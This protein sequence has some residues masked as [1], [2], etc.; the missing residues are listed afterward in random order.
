M[1]QNEP[2]LLGLFAH[3]DDEQLIGA[4]FTQAVRQGARAWVV[5]ATRGEAGQN[6]LFSP[7]TP[8]ALGAARTGE[9]ERAAALLGW[10]PPIFLD[11]PDGGMHEVPIADVTADFVRAIRDIRPDVVVTFDEQGGYGHLDHIA[12]NQ[13][14]LAAF[15]LAADVEFRPEL[16]APHQASKLYYS[17]VPRSVM[18][19][20]FADDETADVG[21]DR[22]TI[23]VSD[24]GAL[25][26]TITTVVSEPELVP[27]LKQSV[28]AHQTQW[29]PE[30]FERM[31]GDR[32]R[33]WFSNNTFVRIHPAPVPGTSLPD[34]DGLLI[35][36]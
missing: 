17:V 23:E 9:M 12:A 25:D 31:Q 26:E 4:A 13:A 30:W 10:E 36:L 33:I 22:R 29:S 18:R 3:P 35:G 24:M 27:L 11:Y 1:T 34:E 5:I 32:Y 15:S 7:S 20:L 8:A 14:A 16:G 19:L 28:F 2:R 6:Y 21:G